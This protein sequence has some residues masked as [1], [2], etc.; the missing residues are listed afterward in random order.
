M[1]RR[2]W[3][4]LALL[5][6]SC[7]SC[8]FKPQP[9]FDRVIPPENVDRAAAWITATV[10]AANQSADDP[11]ESIVEA[12][13]SALDLF[14]E[15]VPGTWSPKRADCRTIVFAPDWSTR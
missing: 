6:L 14:G 7:A 2:A 12:T 9:G 5:A 4:F 8:E 15:V 10:A 3:I 1:R 11:E 13:K